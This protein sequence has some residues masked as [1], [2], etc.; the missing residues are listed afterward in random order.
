MSAV[1]APDDVRT[2]EPDLFGEAAPARPARRATARLTL[3]GRLAAKPHVATRQIDGE[4]HVV[5]VLV[6]ELTDVGAGHH[7]VVAH[8]PY[9]ESTR[10]QAEAEARRLQRDQLVTVSTALIDIRVLL[11]AASLSHDD[12]P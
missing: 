9:T 2:S 8:V 11:R 3:T 12:Q 4:G 7:D 1:L 10:R 5:P 6:L